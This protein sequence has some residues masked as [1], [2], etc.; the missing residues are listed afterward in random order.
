MDM[1]IDFTGLFET[2]N[3]LTH[4]LSAI[5]SAL[6]YIRSFSGYCRVCLCIGLLISNV[7]AK[8]NKL[9]KRQKRNFC[10]FVFIAY[11]PICLIVCHS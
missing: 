10:A 2:R 11:L 4:Y 6:H 3:H 9:H 7:K 8:Y 1:G 5:I